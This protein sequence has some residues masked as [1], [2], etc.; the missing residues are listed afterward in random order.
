[1]LTCLFAGWATLANAQQL[2][3]LMDLTQVVANGAR[4]CVLSRD[5]SLLCWGLAGFFDRRYSGQLSDLVRLRVSPPARAES[6]SIGGNHACSFEFAS[7]LWCRGRNDHGQLGD[8]TR[9]DNAVGVIVPGFEASEVSQAVNG[10]KHT[11]ALRRDGTVWC[12][13]ANFSGQLGDGSFLS[14]SRPVRVSGLSDVA[15]LSAGSEHTCAVTAGGSAHCWGSNMHGRLGSGTVAGSSSTPLP[16]VML[17]GVERI[18]AGGRHTCA[19]VSDGG[20][21]CW[22]NNETGQLGHGGQ[23]N[24][25]SQFPIAVSGLSSVDGLAAGMQHTCAIKDGTGYCWGANGSGQLGDGSATNAYAPVT[26]ASSAR[27]TRISAGGEHTCALTDDNTVECWGSNRET[28]IGEVGQ[29]LSSHPRSVLGL[30]DAVS[31]AAGDQHACTVDDSAS[32]R[33]WGGNTNGQL[34]DGSTRLAVSPRAT[35]GVVEIE[36]VAAGGQQTCALARNGTVHCWGKVFTTSWMPEEGRQLQPT[37]IAGLASVREL[38]VGGDFACAA[39]DGGLVQCW[40]R[41]GRG[42]LGDGSVS[43][44]RA[45]P[46]PVAGLAGAAQLEAGLEHACALTSSGAV[47]CWGSNTWGQLGINSPATTESS[48]PAQVTSLEGIVQIA[49]GASHSCALA[50]AGTVHCW[51]YNLNGELGNDT[52]TNAPL[53]TQVLEIGNAVRIAAGGTHSCALLADNTVKCWGANGSGQLGHG[54]T[55]ISTLPRTVQGLTGT[56]I[57]IAAGSEHTCARMDTGQVQCWGRDQHGQLGDGGRNHALPG[58]V[59]I[60]DPNRRVAPVRAGGDGSSIAA[61]LDA[62]GRFAVYQSAASN[63]ASPEEDDGMADIFRTD[64]E[65]GTT[66]RVSVDDAGGE[67]TGDAIEPAVSADGHRIVFV[68]PDASVN[69]LHGEGVAQREARRAQASHGVYLRNLLPERTGGAA[70]TL[71]IGTALAGGLGTRPQIS[72]DGTAVVFT[73]RQSTRDESGNEQNVHLVR[74]V[75]ADAGIS[76]SEPECVSCRARTADGSPTGYNTGASGTAVLSADGR[77]IAY[78]TLAAN[79]LPDSPSPCPATASQIILRDMAT[80][81]STRVSPAAGF[82]SE[83]CGAVGS[84]LPSIDWAGRSVAF[85]SDH[86]HDPGST[87]GREHVYIRH[88]DGAI[89]RVSQSP[90]GDEG[91]ASSGQATMSGDGTLIAYVSSASNIDPNAFGSNPHRVPHVYRLRGTNQRL[92]ESPLAQQMNGHAER[93]SL[94]YNGTTLG[95]DTTADNLASGAAGATS[96]ASN[97]YIRTVPARRQAVFAANFD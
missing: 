37:L 39:N 34:G 55:A 93:P 6:V 97:V 46:A 14:S 7:S 24:L 95:F 96:A 81:I 68:A 63:L 17:A 76:V 19:M 62:I 16:V 18:A 25:N 4:T 60:D 28:Q 56:V 94:T 3:P 8:G 9:N 70:R 27:F 82:T 10:D 85:Q 58:L 49:L 1:M 13:G 87:P 88:Q 78:E 84:R 11:C 5:G 92:S 75:Q 89:Q 35:L 48:A 12:W 33:C 21:W 53:P 59:R 91:N 51:G 52:R 80:G 83:F 74:L 36:R 86:R 54:P 77:W 71:R 29:N 57:E 45:T 47:L 69:A 23:F 43:N 38:A 50:A 22:G 66:V 40:G 20:L 90:A 73:A 15:Q 65:L 79:P 32:V 44:G 67:I 61:R 41:N 2:P 26:V 72:A 42:Q 31:L 64:L 30:T